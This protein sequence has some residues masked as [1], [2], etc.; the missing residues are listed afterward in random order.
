MTYIKYTW[1]MFELFALSFKI[2][3]NLRTNIERVATH[4]Y[5]TIQK[6][7]RPLQ[8][9]VLIKLY[10]KRQ[11]ISKFRV[12][13]RTHKYRLQICNIISFLLHFSYSILN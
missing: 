11:M 7:N 2:K 4:N 8:I 1:C 12:I 5:V 9:F 13:I 3:I 6:I 10:S